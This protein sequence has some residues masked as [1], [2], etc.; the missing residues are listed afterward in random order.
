MQKTD[1]LPDLRQRIVKKAVRAELL[2]ETERGK[3]L[4]LS[5]VRRRRARDKTEVKPKPST[6]EQINKIE[7]VCLVGN[8]RTNIVSGLLVCNFS[9]ATTNAYKSKDGT[10]IMDTTWFAV[11]AWEGKG[12]PDLSQIQKGSPVHVWGRVRMRSFNTAEGLER[13]EMEVKASR[14]ELL[15]PDIRLTASL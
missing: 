14:V 11:T 10:P 7:I 8:V 15:D 6:M 9:L 5:P 3:S 12:M 13:Q 4:T 2:L 1:L